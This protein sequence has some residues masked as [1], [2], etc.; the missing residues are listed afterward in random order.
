M[1]SPS[2]VQLHLRPI[3]MKLLALA[4]DPAAQVG[5]IA[6]AASKLINALRARGVS[7]VEVMRYGSTPASSTVDTTLA[8]A[9]ATRMPFGKYKHRPLRDVPLSY[10]HW[11]RDNC[12]NMSATLRDAI[13]IVLNE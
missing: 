10:L 4:L 13:L 7:T 9:L 3:E 12:H 8:R 11:T 5:E 6:A 1:A 2:F